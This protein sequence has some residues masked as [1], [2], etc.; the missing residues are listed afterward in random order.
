MAANSL[1]RRLIK[2]VVFP[3]L[4]QAGYAY[5][6]SLAL[7]RDIRSG[8]YSEPEL[9][10]LSLAVR[11]GET[12]L[13]VGANFGLYTYHLSRAVGPSGKVYAFE[14]VPFTNATLRKVVSRLGVRNAEIVPKGC[15]DRTARVTFRLPLQASG[16]LSAGQAHIGQRDDDRAGKEAQVRWGKTVDVECEV[17]ALDEALPELHDLS[18]L[19]CDIEGAEL[20]AFRGAERMI[21]R[22]H[23]TVICE[24]NPWFLEGFGIGLGELVDF[25]SDRGYGLYFYDHR[26]KSLAPIVDLKEV[27]EDNYVFIHKERLERFGALLQ[28]AGPATSGMNS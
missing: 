14:P 27:I 23:P 6:Q 13:D 9:D 8:A 16:A 15:S 5:L 10:L 20:L 24:I 12:V 7:A 1:I 18:L 26:E 2:R 19:K 22:H 4:P 3:L 25:F 21:S 17:V 11:E 28:A